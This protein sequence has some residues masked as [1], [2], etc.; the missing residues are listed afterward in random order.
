MRTIT[1]KRSR[2]HAEHLTGFAPG[3]HTAIVA[4]SKYTFIFARSLES[5]CNRPFMR[6]AAIDAGIVAP[7]HRESTR[8]RGC[9]RSKLSFESIRENQIARGEQACIV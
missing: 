5:I 9:L 1:P 2:V 6:L 3:K 7:S 8:R 4:T